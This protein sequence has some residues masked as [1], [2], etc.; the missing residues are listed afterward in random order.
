MRYHV[1]TESGAAA[2][3]LG[4]GRAQRLAVEHTVGAYLRLFHDAHGLSRDEVRRYG[5]A[6][7]DLLRAE[8]P[9]LCDE[10]LPAPLKTNANYWP[11]MLAP[12]CWPDGTRASVPPWPSSA[13]VRQAITV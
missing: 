3:G 12:N 10:L 6:V 1:S 4:F 7:G 13:G 2:R 8:H 5:E 11:S 9:D